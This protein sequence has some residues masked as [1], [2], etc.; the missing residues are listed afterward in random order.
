VND[1]PLDDRH[2]ETFS[3]SEPEERGKGA[4]YGLRADEVEETDEDRKPG[5]PPNRSPSASIASDSTGVRR[6][7]RMSTTST[8]V[9][10]ASAESTS[11]PETVI[12]VCIGISG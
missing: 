11:A 3:S 5:V 2:G 12:R 8:A 4:P 9:H 7:A 1:G 10:A 6:L